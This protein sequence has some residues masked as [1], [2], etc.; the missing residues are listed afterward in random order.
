MAKKNRERVQNARMA[1]KAATGRVV[2]EKFV[3]EVRPPIQAK[4]EVQKRF[5][6]ALKQYDVV[7]FS[8]P[9]G[10]GKSLLTMSE[11]SDWLKK[12]Q[13]DKITLTRPVIPMGRSLGM[14]PSTLQQKF[15]P[16]LMPL[17]EVLWKRYGKS[18][19]ENC[20]Q[21]GSIELLAPEYAR[22]RSVS[23]CMIIDECFKGDTEVLTENGWQEFS[24]LVE[25]TKVLQVNEDFSSEFV[26]PIR[27][28]KKSYD[29][30]IITHSRDRL[31]MSA[32]ENHDLVTTTKAGKVLKEPFNHTLKT[33]RKIPISSQYSGERSSFD[34]L[35]VVDA[36]LQADGS[37]NTTS[38][39]GCHK[40]FW[41]VRLSRGGKI[42][43]FKKAL[44]ETG[45]THSEYKP[46]SE[47]AVRFYIPEYQPKY[48]S[49]YKSK[50]FCMKRLLSEGVLNQFLE[51]VILWDGHVGKNGCKVYCSTNKENVDIVQAVAHICGKSANYGVTH[52][53]RTIFKSPPKPYYRLNISEKDMVQTDRFVKTEDHYKGQVYCVTV[54]SGM[55]L[56][57]QEGKVFV[58][59]NCQSMYPAELY[60]MLTRM[61]EGA[62][63]IL[64]GD[65]S[66]QQTDI[67]GENAI[68]WLKCFIKDNPELSEYICVIEA[69]SDDIVRSGLTKAMVKAREKENKKENNNE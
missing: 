40:P 9:A 34:W 56:V 43:R 11:A 55:I 7:L 32:T 24:S 54:P 30:K 58:T 46:D 21:N 17:L 31:S 51:E 10:T 68:T 63:L 8:A 57:R 64:I 1:K 44:E 13:I 49:D 37:Y 59:G 4:N 39:G 52:D 3:E 61:E 60:T 38:A 42:E 67:K 47:G 20:L 5:L 41:E 6:N 53:K 2:K 29:G 33:G 15:E 27:N 22:G 23:G 65:D 35:L 28:V 16:Y 45:I 62:K 25:G 66:G 36:A 19:Y 12:G 26:I 14:L 50:T 69:T 48:F 18:Y